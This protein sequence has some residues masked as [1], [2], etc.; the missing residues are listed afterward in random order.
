MVVE[1]SGMQFEFPDGG[2]TVK[3]DDDPFYRNK[4]NK[5]PASKGVDF[6]S[7]SKNTIAFIE[8]KNCTGHEGDNRWRI[9][10]NNQK[11][12]TA[13][14]SHEV[15]ERESLDIEIPQKVA[16]TLAALC[17]VSSFGDRKES[18]DQLAEIAKAVFEKNFSQTE[19][20]KLVILVLEGNFGTFTRPK[21]AIMS[22]LQR[23]IMRKMQWLD[24]KVSVVDSNTYNKKIFRIVS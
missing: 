13:H 16:M 22:E 9:A 1:E 23:S 24:C 20:K 7:D 6:I 19:K 18:L 12:D 10:P 3:F 17:G 15:G 11:R 14:T 4:F 21:S 8:V 5:F 2:T